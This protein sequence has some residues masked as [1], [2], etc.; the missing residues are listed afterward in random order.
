MIIMKIRTILPVLL[1]FTTGLVFGQDPLVPGHGDKRVDVLNYAID[2][3]TGADRTRINGTARLALATT[4]TMREL[5]LD[6]RALTVSRVLVNGQ[7]AQFRRAN[8]KLHITPRLPLE[9]GIPADVSI[10]WLAGCGE[11]KRYDLW[12]APFRLHLVSVQ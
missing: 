2:L 9:A 3:T 12:G 4:E 8:E 6:L 1:C 11:R 7:P 5:S 10:T